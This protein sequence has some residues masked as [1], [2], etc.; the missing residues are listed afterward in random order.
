[1]TLS[2]AAVR[3]PDAALCARL[4]MLGVLRWLLLVVHLLQA[5]TRLVELLAVGAALASAF[6]V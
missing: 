4:A 6:V 5:F 3:D 2:P 1:M